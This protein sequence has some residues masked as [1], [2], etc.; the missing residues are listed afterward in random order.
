MPV[1]Y[2]DRMLPPEDTAWEEVQAA[3]RVECATVSERLWCRAFGDTKASV[4]DVAAVIEDRAAYPSHYPHVAEVKAYDDAVHYTRIGMPSPFADRDQVFR[5]ERV[6]VA[7]ARVYRWEAVTR[8]DAPEIPGVVRLTDAAG[9]WRIEATA[10]GASL[11]YTWCAEM[12]GSFPGWAQWRAAL[13][14]A[15]EMLG[16]TVRAAE[17]R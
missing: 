16:G 2:R 6:D 17:A 13:L 5:A 15:D 10:A 7:D 9:E 12:G 3:P 4:D 14:H 8:A 1:G 11:R